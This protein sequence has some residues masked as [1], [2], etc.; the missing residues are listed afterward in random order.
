L[1]WAGIDR[2]WGFDL[3]RT[4]LE[5]FRE[6][7]EKKG[8]GAGK[9]EKFRFKDMDDSVTGVKGRIVDVDV[10]V[11]DDRVYVIEVKSRAEIEHVEMLSDK[12]R[13]VERV[14]GKPVVKVFIIAVNIDGEAYERARE[15][16]I[17][18]YAVIYQNDVLCKYWRNY[19]R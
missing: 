8:I 3:E 7:L 10:L 4:V 15:L 18:S 5:I 14:L 9:V 6:A 11:R 17:G 16:G 13:A 2:R 12:A 19:R 1:S